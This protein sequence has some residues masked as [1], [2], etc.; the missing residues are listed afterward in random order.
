MTA[1]SLPAVFFV[2]GFLFLYPASALHIFPIQPFLC[3]RAI[4]L[5]YA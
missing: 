1:G 5:S 3:V 4:F 2:C